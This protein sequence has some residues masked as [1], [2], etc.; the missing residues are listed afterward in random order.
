[1]KP[2]RG[3]APPSSGRREPES[4]RVFAIPELRLLQELRAA[5]ARGGMS[6]RDRRTPEDCARL[7][8]FR[9]EEE[10]LRLLGQFKRRIEGGERCRLVE[11]EHAQEP[12]RLVVELVI[13]SMD[14]AP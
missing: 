7:A 9:V 13:E 4:V 12:G 3:S 1:M 5:L 8:L 11:K 6:P 14:G 2:P 10:V